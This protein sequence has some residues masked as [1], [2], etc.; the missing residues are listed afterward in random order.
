MEV[1]AIGTLKGG[2]G[3]TAVTFNVA[4]VLAEEKKVLAIDID[5]QANLSIN[6]GLDTTVEDARTVRDI[7]AN[8]AQA[9]PEYVITEAPI[10]QLPN[11][12]IIASHIRL[13]AMEMQLVS[14]AGRE[15]VI[16]KWIKAH[17]DFLQKYDYI[18]IDTNPSMSIINQNAFV[19]ADSIVLVSDI[20]EESKMGVMQFVYLWDEIRE[21][22]D[23]E[24]NVKAMVLNNVDKRMSQSQEL[25]DYYKTDEDLMGLLVETFIPYRVAIKN[26]SKIWKPINISDPKS[27]ACEAV[28]AVVENLKEKGVF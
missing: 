16:S 10:P 14:R 27:D 28:R 2:T 12:D 6:A 15:F 24:D 3:K 13:T 19:A 26:T 22:Y 9:K 4:G 5:P 17:Y 11:L 20:S 1:I 23:L 8:P 25:M 18:L 7:F 21:A